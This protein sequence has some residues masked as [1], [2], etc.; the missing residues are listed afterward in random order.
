MSQPAP[1]NDFGHFD[2]FMD[3]VERGTDTPQLAVRRSTPGNTDFVYSLEAES[4]FLLIPG[5]FRDF[6]GGPH[7]TDDPGWVVEPGAFLAND[8]LRFRALG[9]LSFYDRQLGKWLSEPPAG[10]RVR[11]FGAIPPDVFIGGDPAELAFY[12]QG[13]IWSSEGLEG[14]T[15]SAIEQAASDGSIHTHLDF[16]V[17]DSTGDCSLPGIGNTGNPAVGAY[18][19]EL[20]LFSDATEGQNQPRY[21]DAD[22]VKVI[23]NN[24][25]IADECEAAIGALSQRDTSPQ[26]RTP[27]SG[28]LIIGGE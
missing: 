3:V 20:Q 23:L 1:W 16:C 4:R 26:D 10:E 11:F 17:E 18:M 22:P 6:G 2:V 27:A 5:D 15:E 28:I 14:P 12:Q 13:T 7:K 24:G 25:L 21:L 8:V 9:S 19:I